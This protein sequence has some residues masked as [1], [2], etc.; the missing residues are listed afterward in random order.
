MSIYA[1]VHGVDTSRFVPY[2]AAYNALVDSHP[3]HQFGGKTAAAASR[4]INRYCNELHA[5][6]IVVRLKSGTWLADADRFPEAAVLLVT[7]GSLTAIK[8]AKSRHRESFT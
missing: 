5:A 7:G 6:R 2:R 3:H 4:F 8:A 1:N